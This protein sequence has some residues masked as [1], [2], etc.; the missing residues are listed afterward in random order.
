MTPIGKG[1]LQVLEG[2]NARLYKLAKEG[3]GV[4]DST[5]LDSAG[6]EARSSRNTELAYTV[7]H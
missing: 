5:V 4:R 6:D 2:E 7:Y 1:A 3:E